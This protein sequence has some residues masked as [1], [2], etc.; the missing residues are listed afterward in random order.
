M[1]WTL[2]HSYESREIVLEKLGSGENPV[3]LLG[4]VHGDER[5]GYVF[6]EDYID[7]FKEDV[8][9]LYAVQ[10]VNPDGCESGTLQNSR[11]VDLNRNFPAKD[12]NSGPLKKKNFAGDSPA[13]EVETGIII[14]LIN[15]LAPR[16]IISAHSWKPMINYDGPAEEIA[17]EMSRYSGYAVQSDIGY[18]TPGSLGTW[19]GSELGIPTVTLEIEKGLDINEIIKLHRDSVTR[20]FRKSII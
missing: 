17:R 20:G 13:S 2:G 6:V 11:G 15:E 9:T 5:E 7:H 3:L 8:F 16:C 14:N 1:N 18:A 19:A 4:G 10:R 12:W